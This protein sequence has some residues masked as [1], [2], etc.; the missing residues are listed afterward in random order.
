MRGLRDASTV[1]AGRMGER[2]RKDRS[3]L[4]IQ[5]MKVVI[6]RGVSW[7]ARSPLDVQIA[8]RWSDLDVY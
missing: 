1:R 8:S 3:H 2:T 5:M 4:Q 6:E 7:A